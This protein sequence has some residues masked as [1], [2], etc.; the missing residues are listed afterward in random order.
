MAN[1]IN[2]APGMDGAIAVTGAGL[3]DEF[4][5]KNVA[6]IADFATKLPDDTMGISWKMVV[7]GAVALIAYKYF[8][9]K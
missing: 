2:W 7:L 4:V 1:K 6:A 5:V 9:P 8:V 3:L